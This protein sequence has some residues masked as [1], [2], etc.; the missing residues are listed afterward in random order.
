MTYGIITVMGEVEED[1]FTSLVKANKEFDEQDRMGWEPILV[2][3]IKVGTAKKT[4]IYK[5]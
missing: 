4:R 3:I 5:R 2:K 1:W